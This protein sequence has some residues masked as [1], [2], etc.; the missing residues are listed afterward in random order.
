MMGHAGDRSDTDIQELTRVA[1][2]LSPERIVLFELEEY[3]RGRPL[4]EVS[5]VM[6]NTLLQ[7]GFDMGMVSL[8]PSPSD[9]T[10]DAI[11]W[12]QDGDFLLLLA[13]GDREKVFEEI[14]RYIRTAS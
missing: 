6:Y 11:D 7:Q 13:L 5:N 9:G 12:A 4:G 2:G 3:L 10:R 1:L 14:D 8:A